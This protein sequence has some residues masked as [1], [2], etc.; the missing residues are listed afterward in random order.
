MKLSDTQRI[1]LSQASQRDDR[2]AI[3]P[4]RLPAAARQT[5]AKALIKQGFV[6][7]EHASAYNARDAWQID[8]RTRLLRITEAGLRAIGVTPEG[9]AEEVEDTRPRD[10]RNGV[11]PRL[12]D[13]GE[14]VAE[15]AT[16]A[17]TAP[18]G[19][20][21]ALPQDT[22]A[23]NAEAALYPARRED[24]A[25]LDQALATPR[26]ARSVTLREVAQRILDVWDDEANQRTALPSAIDALRVALATKPGGPKREAG[27]PRKPREGTKQETVL[28]MLRR[29]EGATIAQICEAT[30]WQQ[31]T[32]RGFFAGL[33]KR[34]GIE[35]QVMER[36]RQV[37]PNKEGARGSYSVYRV[38][39]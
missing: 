25:L 36:V 33:K 18:T 27:A 17:D 22:P 4:E 26:Q 2:L 29:E 12:I 21:D 5:V 35:V 37:G 28:A 7:D 14:E 11:D 1:I 19:G 13:G 31:H 34:Q 8:G 38:S 3:P 10:E 6:S 23:A 24:V 9:V 32:V 30:G 20:K 39:Q 16:V 15:P